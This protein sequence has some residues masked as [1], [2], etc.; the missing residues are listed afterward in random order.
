MESYTLIKNKN[1]IQYVQELNNIYDNKLKLN[2]K[3][4]LIKTKTNEIS[5]FDL[6]KN[7]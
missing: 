6:K 2:S 3:F 7:V 5:I 1:N 4:I